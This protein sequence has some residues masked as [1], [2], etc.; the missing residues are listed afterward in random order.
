MT[1]ALA[2]GADLVAF[3]GTIVSAPEPY[4]LDGQPAAV[5]TLAMD[6][7]E[8]STVRVVAYSFGSAP[9]LVEVGARRQVRGKFREVPGGA[10][11]VLG[12]LGIV[13]DMPF[14]YWDTL[15]VPVSD[16]GALAAA[17][18]ACW[19]PYGIAAGCHHLRRRTFKILT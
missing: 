9:E 4:E 13:P 8:P 18:R 5:L 10:V 3:V 14:P 11:L 17:L 15:A 19:E 12:C 6:G 1:D 7:P 16:P 2:P